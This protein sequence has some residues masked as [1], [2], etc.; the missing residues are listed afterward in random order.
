[1]SRRITPTRW[2]IQEKVF[3]A[4]GF[5]L[6]REAASHRS[7]VKPGIIRP[8]VIPKYKEVPVSIIQNNMTT[9]NMSRERYFELLNKVK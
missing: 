4:D 6:A 8:V 1:M 5:V 3:L 9:A 2:K 7:Y